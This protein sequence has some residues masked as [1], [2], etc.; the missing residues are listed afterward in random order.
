MVRI[1]QDPNWT[2]FLMNYSSIDTGVF[3]FQ[4]ICS[5]VFLYCHLKGI[6]QVAVAAVS[7]HIEFLTFHLLS[8]YNMKFSRRL[9]WLQKDKKEVKTYLKY[10]VSQLAYK[11]TIYVIW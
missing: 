9:T 3:S 5:A 2:L 4:F 6:I 7:F 11:C 1:E 10:F 8:I